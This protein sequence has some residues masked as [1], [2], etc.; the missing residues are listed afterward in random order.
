LTSDNEAEA[1]DVEIFPDPSLAR[2]LITFHFP[3]HTGRQPENVR[4]NF[5]LAR[6]LYEEIGRKLPH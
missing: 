1:V 2:L 4:L 5:P 3:K 6:K